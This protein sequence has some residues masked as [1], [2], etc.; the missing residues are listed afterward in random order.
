MYEIDI[1]S[2]RLIED[3]ILKH[4]SDIHFIPQK[5]HCSIQYRVRGQMSEQR[6][7]T[8]HVAERMI[9]HFKYMSGMDIGERRKPQS[10]AMTIPSKH[11]PY[12]LR[13]S[14]LPSTFME[15]LAIRLLPQ[16]KRQS[17]HNLP[18]LYHQ[19]KNLKNISQLAHG[20]VLICGPTSSG[21]T[22]TLYALAEEILHPKT[23]T[24]VTIEDPVERPIESAV[25]IEI[26]ERA[27]VTF[28][29]GLRAT[30]RHDPDVIVVGEI[31]EKATA[32]LAIRAALTGHLVLASMHTTD[33][34][35]AVLRLQ[36][37]GIS[38][39]EVSEVCRVIVAQRLISTTSNEYYAL[40]EFLEKD[41]LLS[42]IQ[43]S[44]RPVYHQLAHIAQKAWML[45]FIDEL[46]LHRMIRGGG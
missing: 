4:V 29:T 46:S 44:Q 25:Q 40:Y 9:S 15:S 1:E 11:G 35:Q 33:A 6:R 3:A 14:T 23:K 21:K 26:N 39:T 43:S 22:T 32:A 34:F 19:L 2:S 36:E 17:L 8:Q 24:M 38:K 13:L 45:G 5:D 28:E 27:G 37:Y 12:S 10:M 42:G 7:M 31:R 16:K 18:L 20:L 30:L 41:A